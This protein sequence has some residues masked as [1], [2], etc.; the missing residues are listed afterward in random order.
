MNK[1]F[2]LGGGANLYLSY[3][4]NFLQLCSGLLNIYENGNTAKLKL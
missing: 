2:F 3:S 1:Y 4:S